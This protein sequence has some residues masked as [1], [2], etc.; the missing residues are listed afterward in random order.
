MASDDMHVVIYK[1]LAYIYKCMKCGETP[2]K[3]EISAEALGIP[4]AYWAQIISE[5]CSHG[6][7]SGIS[8]VK[9]TSGLSVTLAKPTI[10]L[11]GVE[12]LME[13]SMMTK[14]VKFLQDTKSAI[15]FI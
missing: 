7:V 9:T 5:L 10:T 15:P 13:N 3:G 2:E 14:A 12:F 6:Y 8:V 1:I 4:Y 11:D